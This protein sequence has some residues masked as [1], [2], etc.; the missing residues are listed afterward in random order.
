MVSL[1]V[2][3]L[4]LKLLCEAKRDLFANMLREKKLHPR[5][6]LRCTTVKN[7]NT[8]KLF[9]VV[10]DNCTAKSLSC[11]TLS[12]LNYLVTVVNFLSRHLYGS[13][14]TCEQNWS[15]L[16]VC[17]VCFLRVFAKWEIGVTSVCI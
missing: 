11:T 8:P 4:V 2:G 10:R 1:Q 6:T 13:C 17:T 9:F 3:Y 12:N 15:L 16:V 7:C 14:F 5:N